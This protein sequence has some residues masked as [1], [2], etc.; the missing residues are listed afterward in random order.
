MYIHDFQIQD[1]GGAA[2]K[3]KFLACMAFLFHFRFVLGQF[4]LKILAMC[5]RFRMPYCNIEMTNHG[6]TLIDFILMLFWRA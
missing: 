2:V 1:I 6:Y 5:S 3:A 4:S